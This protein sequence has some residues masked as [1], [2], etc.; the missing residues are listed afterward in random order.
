M[1]IRW[2]FQPSAAR[3]SAAHRKLFGDIPAEKVSNIFDMVRK[4]NPARPCALV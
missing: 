3:T 2:R 1:D 4:Y